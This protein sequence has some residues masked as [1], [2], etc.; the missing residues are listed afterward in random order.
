[1]ARRGTAVGDVTNILQSENITGREKIPAMM[2]GDT[3][4]QVVTIQ[5][6]KEYMN[7]GIEVDEE[8]TIEEIDELLNF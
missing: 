2:Q 8:L 5:E 7:Q 3:E 1:M 4:P 6:L